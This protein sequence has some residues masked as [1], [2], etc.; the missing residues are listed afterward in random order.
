MFKQSGTIEVDSGRHSSY[1]FKILDDNA[2]AV[3]QDKLFIIHGNKKLVKSYPDVDL[4]ITKTSNCLLIGNSLIGYDLI[5]QDRSSINEPNLKGF[6]LPF[7]SNSSKVY[8]FHRDRKLGKYQSGLYDTITKTFSLIKGS[9]LNINFVDGDIYLTAENTRIDN[10]GNDLWKLDLT[11]LENVEVQEFLGVYQ[12]QLLVACSNHLLLSV[13]ANTGEVIRKWRELPGFDASQSYKDVLPEPSDFVLD[14]EAGKLIGVFSKYY[15][16]IDI[17]SG[18]ISYEDVRQ[19]LNAHHINSFRRMGRNNTFT[20]DHL[21]VT[22]HAELDERPNVDLD[23]VLALNR[24]TKKVDW[25]HIFKDTGLGTNAPQM[26]NT[27]L[28]QLDTE[29]NLYIFEKE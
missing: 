17:I 7:D 20:K 12:N 27:H 10:K 18:Q 19:E 21:F 13:N 16:E 14:K 3:E 8:F 24:N 15:F 6:Q 26:T 22:A 28:Y 11:S 29:K 2:Y 9:I 1:W 25:V 23:C 5:T 4:S